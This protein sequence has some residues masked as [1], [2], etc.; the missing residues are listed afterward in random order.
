MVTHTNCMF[1]TNGK[2][3]QKSYVEQSSSIEK[4]GQ[5]RKNVNQ[6]IC[7]IIGLDIC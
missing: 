3:L 2:I 1:L 6:T 7:L 4:H 5:I